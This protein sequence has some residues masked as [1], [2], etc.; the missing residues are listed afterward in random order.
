MTGQSAAIAARH[1]GQSAPC[2]LLSAMIRGRREPDGRPRPR[3]A[4]RQHGQERLA[5]PRAVRVEAAH[6]PRA[7][8]VAV[9]ERVEPCP[10][11]PK[12]PHRLAG[13]DTN[14]PLASTGYRGSSPVAGARRQSFPPCVGV[15]RVPSQTAAGE[16]RAKGA[17][18]KRCL[19]RRCRPLR[20]K[21]ETAGTA[22]S[23]G[24]PSPGERRAP[25]PHARP[26]F[27]PP[28]AER[29]DARLDR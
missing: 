25:P 14:T 12:R 29:I 3:P 7:C 16:R 8:P 22:R 27:V 18:T 5:R 21:R 10:A 28:K 6:E 4:P 9:P 1:D 19:L 26:F 17:L 24:R 20:W 15:R 23:C 13:S 11:C 2:R